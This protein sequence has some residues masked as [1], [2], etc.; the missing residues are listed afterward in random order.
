LPPH[1]AEALS[2]MIQKLKRKEK[3][4]RRSRRKRGVREGKRGRGKLTIS[5]RSIRRTLEVKLL[6]H[7]L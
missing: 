6:H 4:G 3:K 5:L 7:H 1:L 2:S